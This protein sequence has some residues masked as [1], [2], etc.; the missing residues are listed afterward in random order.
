MFYNRAISK[1]ELLEKTNL[2]IEHHNG[3][4]WIVENEK[5]NLRISTWVEIDNGN[6]TH[7][8]ILGI[9]ELENHGFKDVQNI[10]DEL[11]SKF[12]LL[13]YTD[14]EFQEYLMSNESDMRLLVR[15]AMRRNG[16]YHIVDYDKGI[17]DIPNRTNETI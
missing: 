5:S 15:E 9:R 14:N 3:S 1:K 7:E 6:D 4:D 13:F 8:E 10:L 12:N 16:N 17:V 2:T 11:V